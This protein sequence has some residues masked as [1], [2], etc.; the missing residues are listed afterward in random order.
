MA[1]SDVAKRGGGIYVEHAQAPSLPFVHPQPS[2]D[3]DWRSRDGQFEA[4]KRSERG[5]L[6]SSQ[7]VEC[8]GTD[9]E[10]GYE[11]LHLRGIHQ[12]VC[13]SRTALSKRKST[14]A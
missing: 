4:E 6:T 7:H 11:D 14:E 8:D 12:C 13:H 10:T 3:H 2:D 1:R 5:F 9:P